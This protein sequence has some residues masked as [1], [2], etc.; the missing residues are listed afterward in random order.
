MPYAQHD[1]AGV[2]IARANGTNLDW[3]GP[4][5]AIPGITGSPTLP[6]GTVATYDATTHDQAATTGFKQKRAALADVNDVTFQIFWDPD[7]T[8]IH[9]LILADMQ[10]RTTRQYRVTMF[11]VIRKYG[12]QGQIGVGNLT[13]NIDGGLI[14][15]VTIAANAV[16]FN[17][18]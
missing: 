11:G 4:W 3:L 17:V 12:V 6:G 13:A 14:A 9:Q 5:T 10:A 8:A 18:T 15:T 1:G 7:D 2:I 16:N